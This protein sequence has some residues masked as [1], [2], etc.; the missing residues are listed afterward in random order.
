MALQGSAPT[1][2]QGLDKESLGLE[3]K[4]LDDAL[5][6]LILSASG[7]R[8]IFT[9][10]G[11][12]EDTNREISAAHK[13]IIALAAKVFVDYLKKRSGSD[14]AKI[15]VLTGMD[16]RPTG[17]AIA[18]T[19]IR[20]FLTLQCD[21]RFAGVVAIPELLSYARS[22]GEGGGDTD[23]KGF[24]YISASHNPIAYNGLKFGLTDGSVLSARE[25]VKLITAFKALTAKE[26]AVSLAA[27]L[28]NHPVPGM[29]AQ[30]FQKQEAVK[31]S[32]FKSY[33]LFTN[34]VVTGKDKAEHQDFI[35]NTIKKSIAENPLSI[36]ADFNG[37]ARTVSIDREFLSSLGINLRAINDQKGQI[38]HRI[39]P[40]RESLEPCRHL[41]E[42]VHARDP[43]AILGYMPDCDGDRGNLVIWDDIRKRTEALE[44]QEVFALACISEL[45]YLVWT[46]ELT[47]SSQGK[48]LKKAAVA[49]NDPTSLRIDRIAGVFDVSVFRSEVGEANVVNL[50]RKL[51]SQGYTVRILGEGS[52]GGNI[53]YPAEVRDPMNTI[54][55]IVKLLTIRGKSNKP[56]LFKI[57]CD[58]SKNSKSY[59]SDFKLKDI[60]N[61]LPPFV[62]TSA[63]S[64]DAILR[65][66]TTD[67]ILLKRRYESVFRR[68]WERSKDE[69][70]KRYGIVAWKAFA[71]V[72]TEEKPVQSDFG[73]SGTGGLKIIFLREDNRSI[74]CIWMRGSGTEPVFRIMADT[75][76]RDEIFER[77]LIDWQHR[78]LI[79]ADNTIWYSKN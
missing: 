79:E 62:T 17:T 59:R 14:D 43:A 76:G 27:Y 20:S 18:G 44:A 22:C 39:V 3:R 65:L 21:V 74:A 35:F 61:S 48:A 19:M 63:Y 41:L 54:M 2:A 40:E 37:S 6:S 55:S 8:G 4:Q 73:V 28:I 9:G 49:V 31:E 57:W 10:N 1:T 12:E 38:V 34:R 70:M 67:H 32:C 36:C 45:A 5:H 13:V 50:A 51:R 16:S 64:E 15:A 69:L 25:S 77:Y 68:E 23:V 46:G 33:L 53:T 24:V 7:W 66:E 56:G 72:G 42:K 52:A 30:V 47:Y 11:N 58:L 75:E 78:M 71:Y 60:L 26:N 29:I